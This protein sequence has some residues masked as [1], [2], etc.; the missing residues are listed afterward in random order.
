MS[1]LAEFVG[2]AGRAHALLLYA[3]AGRTPGLAG[4]TSYD[5]TLARIT[6]AWITQ[7]RITQA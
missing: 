6:Q 7:A 1:F 5:V 3:R 2:A 4:T